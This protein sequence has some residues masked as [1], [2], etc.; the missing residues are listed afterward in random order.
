MVGLD[1]DKLA[2]GLNAGDRAISQAA[3]A[4][5]QLRGGSVLRRGLK[6]SALTSYSVTHAQK[7]IEIVEPQNSRWGPPLASTPVLP[8]FL[9]LGSETTCWSP[10]ER[11]GSPFAI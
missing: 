4:R 3:V 10:S 2:G 7:L 9:A 8:I 1:F 5:N 6:G 11:P